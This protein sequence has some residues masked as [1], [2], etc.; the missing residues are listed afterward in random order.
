[1]RYYI[2]FGITFILLLFILFYNPYL[3]VYN[4]SISIKYEFNDEDYHWEYKLNN[5]NLSLQESDKNYWK[6]IPNKNGK[7]TVTFF[8]KNDQSI[9]YKIIYSF[10]VKNKKI[11]WIDGEGYGLLDFPNPY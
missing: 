2:I 6:F 10:K 9:K 1:M 4:D 11:Y 8:Y 3:G 5:D 7:T